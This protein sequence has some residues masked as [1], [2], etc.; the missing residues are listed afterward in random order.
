MK[1]H[2]EITN[3]DGETFEG[4]A[5]LTPS[6][7]TAKL[8]K[9]ESHHKDDSAAS[10]HREFSF[11]SNPRA[12]MSSHGKGMSGSQRFTLLLA[13]LAKGQVTQ[14]IPIEQIAS[15]WNL[16][17]SVMGGAF[18]PAYTTRAKEKGWV[19]SPKKGVYVL[20]NSW[21]EIFQSA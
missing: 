10:S 2:I 5:T 18:N 4:T 15:T 19:D 17:K 7:K 3:D 11:S 16:M 6:P 13:R 12:F 20:T 9:K 8:K 14:E 21:K 1:I